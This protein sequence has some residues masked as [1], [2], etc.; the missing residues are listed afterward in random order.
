[1]PRKKLILPAWAI[2]FL[3]IFFSLEL[4]GQI[5]PESLLIQF[6]GPD[7]EILTYYNYETGEFSDNVAQN[8]RGYFN[9][10]KDNGENWFVAQA[11]Y[12]GDPSP[13]SITNDS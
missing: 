6:C 5:Q 3:A 8:I 10:A 9:W 1:M 4:H 2:I 7:V 13:N 12:Y 11:I